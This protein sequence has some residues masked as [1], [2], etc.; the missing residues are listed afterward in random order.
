[1]SVTTRCKTVTISGVAGFAIVRGLR[2]RLEKM[3]S[4]RKAFE[5]DESPAG[6][7]LRA[8]FSTQIDAIHVAMAA[9]EA[10]QFTLVDPDR[11]AGV[12][13]ICTPVEG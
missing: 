11:N 6:I 5:G 9:M 13:G 10:A 4:R 2:D 12:A 3:V 1:M 7:E 8:Y